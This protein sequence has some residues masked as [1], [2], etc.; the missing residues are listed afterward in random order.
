[1]EITLTLL[2]E[3]IL[4]F[5]SNGGIKIQHVSSIYSHS[6]SKWRKLLEALRNG[7]SYSLVDD[8]IYFRGGIHCGTDQ[9][10]I[11]FSPRSIV[12]ETNVSLDLNMYRELLVSRLDTF[13]EDTNVKAKLQKRF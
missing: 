5:I 4:F 8:D 6:D 12:R 10:I 3:N 7:T 9:L 2:G 13:L 11:E 1:M